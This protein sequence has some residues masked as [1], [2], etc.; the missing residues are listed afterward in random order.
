MAPN[1]HI[2]IPD[3]NTAFGKNLPWS[4]DYMF[5]TSWARMT[6]L[7]ESFHV[8][9]FRNKYRLPG[10]FWLKALNTNYRYEPEA[11]KDFWD[12]GIEQQAM[13]VAERW[14]MAYTGDRTFY[15]SLTATLAQ[16]KALVPFACVIC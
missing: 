12:C 7:H 1:G 11:G 16:I 15:G 10:V 6:I 5:E 9:Q 2:Y 14:Y 4:E 3:G 8:Y 13:M